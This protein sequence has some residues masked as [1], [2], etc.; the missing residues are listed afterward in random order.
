MEE[1]FLANGIFL[2]FAFFMVMVIA[3]AIP[4]RLWVEAIS[5]GVSVGIGSLVGMRLRKV[6]PA[7]I[8]RPL[9]TATKAGLDLD[10]NFSDP[11]GQRNTNRIHW[12][13]NGAAITYDLPTEARLEPELWGLGILQ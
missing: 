8:V 11:A 1:L 9:I 6:S 5:A 10:I 4:V 12:A 2:I 13:R 7:A 3:W